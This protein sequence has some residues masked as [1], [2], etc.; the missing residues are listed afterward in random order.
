[1]L[2]EISLRKKDKFRILDKFHSYVKS[3]KQKK[4]NRGRE[5]RVMKC[6]KVVKRL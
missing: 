2:S 5:W 6:V 1:M 4:K 3:K